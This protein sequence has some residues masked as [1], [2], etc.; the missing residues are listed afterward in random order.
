MKTYYIIILAI[1]F[2]FPV[3]AQ[4]ERKVIVEHFTNTRCGICAARNPAFFQT[5]DEYQQVLHIAYHPSSPYVSCDF[6]QHNPTENDS[7]TNFYNIYGGTP[8]VVIQGE[9]V[10]PGNPLI[11][12]EKIDEHL[13][14]NSNYRVSVS[15]SFVSGDTY[16]MTIEIERVGGTDAETILIY[17]GLAEKEV[18]YSAPN[19]EDLHHDVF[20]KTMFYDT[21]SVNTNDDIK[22]I[23]M[24]YTAHEDWDENEIFA[25]AIIHNNETM[26]VEQSASSLDSPTGILKPVISNIDNLVYPNPASDVIKIRD[27]YIDTFVQAELYAITGNRVGVFTNLKQIDVSGLTNGMYFLKLTDKDNK[28]YSTRVLKNSR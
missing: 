23:E 5:L 4:L 11:S 10:P 12:P 28:Q 18:H 14:K 22:I 2:S 26:E 9:V 6:S 13:G 1:L 15:K 17:S 7:R 8:R 24:E 20:R 27:E 19:G 21:E 3:V 25:Y 16:K